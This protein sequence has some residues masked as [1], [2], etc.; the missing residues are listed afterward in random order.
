[1]KHTAFFAAVLFAANI[2]AM[3]VQAQGG[4]Q[5]AYQ[6]TLTE[7]RHTGGYLPESEGEENT[8]SRWDLCDINS[9]GIPEL[10]ISPDSTHAF[11]CLVYTYSNGT[12]VPLEAREGQTF[13]EYG[14]TNVDTESHVI[15]AYHFGMGTEMIGYYAFD[16]TSLTELDRFVGTSVYLGEGLGTQDTYQQN[17]TEISEVA[18]TAAVDA[19]ESRNWVENVGRA[20]SFDNFAPLTGGLE[21]K[22]V[23]NMRLAEIVGC[24][25]ALL[26]AVGAALFSLRLRRRSACTSVRL[27]MTSNAVKGRQGSHEGGNRRSRD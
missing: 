21:L 5:D 14:V 27:P 17:G 7:Y 25:S 9:D 10:F 16:G 12:A 18:Y 19:Y 22:D 1:M 2:T 8:G 6:Q 20:Y 3:P 26:L 13:G 15:R 23:P 24:G 4:W 11:G